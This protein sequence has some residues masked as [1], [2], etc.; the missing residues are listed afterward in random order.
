MI[1]ASEGFY[2]GQ[3]VDPTYAQAFAPVMESQLMT[4]GARLADLLNRFLR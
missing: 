3:F 1:V 2:P 4:A